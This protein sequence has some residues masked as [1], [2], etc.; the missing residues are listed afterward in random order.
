MSDLPGHLQVIAQ[1][2]LRSRRLAHSV[3]RRFPHRPEVLVRTEYAPPTGI[4]F[5]H[6]FSRFV[7]A[8]ELPPLCLQHGRPAIGT[9]EASIGFSGSHRYTTAYSLGERYLGEDGLL[10]NGIQLHRARMPDRDSVLHADLPVC[11]LVS[12]ANCALHLRFPFGVFT[13]ICNVI[14]VLAFSQADRIDIA[15]P[16]VITIFPGWIPL[17]IINLVTLFNRAQPMTAARLTRDHHVAI[18]THRRFADRF[19]SK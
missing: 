7:I 12:P 9:Y 15:R 1:L 2:E 4:A 16:L 13:A 10:T 17:G 19:A 18:R 5:D 14:A 8:D 3:R 11:R 6:R